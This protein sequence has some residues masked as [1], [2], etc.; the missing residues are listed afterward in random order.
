MTEVLDVHAHAMP[1]PVLHWLAG[2]GL[3]DLTGL[4]EGIV[5]LDRRVSGLASDTAPIP[6]PPEQYDIDARLARMNREGVGRQAISL[7]PFLTCSTAPETSLVREVVRA[8]NDALAEF[9]A[10][11]PGRL[12][13]L[14]SAPVGVPF[15]AEEARRCLDELGMSGIACG[16]QGNARELDHSVNDDL[17][18]MLAA[19]RTFTFV[20]PSSAPGIERMPDLWLPQLAGYPMET[21]LAAARLV[22]SGVLDHHDLT[23]CLAHGGGC[24]PSLRGRLTMG[25]ERKPQARR[26][27]TPPSDRIDAFYY[28]TAVFSTAQL[29]QLIAQVGADHVMVGTDFPFDLAD[30]D[31]GA[32][33]RELRLDASE[34]ALI[35]HRNAERVLGLPDLTHTA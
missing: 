27:K 35:R 33:L 3:A 9:A 10:L 28:D 29:R 25:W 18:S 11:A 14:G 24:L 2:R 32:T 31:P 4:D 6:C 1:L 13:A 7:P 26:A 34:S 20:H 23:L 17:W 21:A 19:R 8:G 16:T 12:V 5:R 30:T 15:A 22:L